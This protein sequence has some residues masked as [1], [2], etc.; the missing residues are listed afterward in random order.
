VCASSSVD[1]L[2]LSTSGLESDAGSDLC[3][4]LGSKSF[5]EDTLHAEVS[6]V[7]EFFVQQPENMVRM[8]CWKP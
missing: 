5:R 7:K 1:R 4:E 6:F 2:H 3:R 8:A